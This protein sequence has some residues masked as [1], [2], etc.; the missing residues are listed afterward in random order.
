VHPRNPIVL[1]LAFVC[2]IG[3]ATIPSAGASIPPN[4]SGD[5]GPSSGAYKV[6]VCFTTPVAN[7]VVSGDATVTATVDVTPAAGPAPA[8]GSVLFRLNSAGAP[9]QGTYLLT[10]FQGTGG[11]P[12]IFSFVVPTY[13]WPDGSRVLT[14]KVRMADGYLSNPAATLGVSFSNPGG[15][16]SATRTFTPHEPTVP[17]GSDHVTVAAVGDG[18]IGNSVADAVSSEVS[19]LQPDMFLYLA[20]VYEV[21]SMAE[22]YNWYGPP[23]GTPGCPGTTTGCGDWG[24]FYSITNPTQG[25]HEYNAPPVPGQPQETIAS[26]YSDYWGT[27]DGVD[28]T[29]KHYYSYDV[30]DCSGPGSVCWHFIS[31]D[32]TDGARPSDVNAPEYS[33]LTNDLQTN[34]GTNCTV[35]Y[36]HHPYW[37]MKDRGEDG[38]PGGV[39]ARLNAMY[40]LLYDHGVDILLTGHQ[41]NF[42]RWQPIDPSGARNLTY[43]ITEIVDGAGGHPF[44]FFTRTD[45]RLVSGIDRTGDVWRNGQ[46]TGVSSPNDSPAGVIELKLFADHADYRYVLAGGDHNGETF[47]PS[48]GNPLSIPC[49]D[50]PSDKVA[51]GTP[52]NVHA[53]SVGSSSVDL[54]WN[55][56]D[57]PDDDLAGYNVFRATGA[58]DQAQCAISCV[59]I[60]TT[61]G[62]DTTFTDP[63]AKPGTVYTY[64]VKARDTSGNISGMSQPS[65][66]TTAPPP[67]LFADDF[68]GSGAGC[69]A[70]A[71][72]TKI[73]RLSIQA[74]ANPDP[75]HAG[76][77]DA[78][79][80]TPGQSAYALKTLASPLGS[81][82]AQVRFRIDS[83]STTASLLRLKGANGQT[84]LTASSTA[85]GLLSIRNEYTNRSSK[86]TANVRAGTGWHTLTVHLAVGATDHVDAWLDGTSVLSKDDSFGTSAVGSVVI[87][88]NVGAHTYRIAL[89]NVVVDPSPIA[90]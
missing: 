54:S 84:L 56:A 70:S 40:Q 4:C 17:A 87:G 25:V 15:D 59:Q 18:A 57:P 58:L 12:R 31:L 79:N 19:A 48:D 64:G 29:H 46:D 6:N 45:P 23:P 1:V 49:H 47:D 62:P 66:V 2:L 75:L 24:Q 32:S 71:G 22:Y 80:L 44:G 77:C 13:R 67:R 16:P 76:T 81:I 27:N 55:A 89:D 41:H 43:G 7:A 26:G 83:Q 52:T 85:G 28:D 35:A 11:N 34:S 73:V 60:G 53:T 90:P 8:I 78:T 69:A 42:Q 3:L 39:D 61:D 14:A 5:S 21:G 51:P 68:E 37:G 86:T 88:D 74:D 82:Y 30:G 36:W 9:G 65:T 10:D 20:D 72:W 63:T 50:A 38:V 33:W